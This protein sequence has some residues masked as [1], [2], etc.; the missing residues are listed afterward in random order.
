MSAWIDLHGCDF[1]LTAPNLTY[2]NLTLLARQFFVVGEQ[3]PFL[4]ALDVPAQFRWA[5]YLQILVDL[6]AEAQGPHS[7]DATKLN[8]ACVIV[9]FL[10][11]HHMHS[12][13]DLAQIPVPTADGTIAL[14]SQVA[15]VK[16]FNF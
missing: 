13:G 12:L 6:H 14:T 11:T 7:L 1:Y 4:G 8:A 10:A 2:P 9:N 5:D 16:Y 3:E 15:Y